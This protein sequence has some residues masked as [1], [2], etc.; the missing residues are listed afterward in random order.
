MGK[1]L[2]IKGMSMFLE[3]GFMSSLSDEELVTALTQRRDSLTDT[4][5]EIELLNR[6]E[7]YLDCTRTQDLLDRFNAVS[8]DDV[9]ALADESSAFNSLTTCRELLAVL[10]AAEYDNAETLKN[11]LE[12]LYRLREVL[13]DLPFSEPEPQK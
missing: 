8:L 5:A 2:F 3:P 4:A 1:P 6:L 11:D 10:S 12:T 7:G 9:D 13:A